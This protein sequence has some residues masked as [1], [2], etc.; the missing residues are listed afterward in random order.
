MVPSSRGSAGVAA[1]VFAAVLTL[2]AVWLFAGSRSGSLEEA[3]DARRAARDPGLNPPEAR[4]LL[5]RV[6]DLSK[7]LGKQ[8]DRVPRDV[9]LRREAPRDKPEE[10]L[11][12]PGVDGLEGKVVGSTILLTWRATGD[13]A[14]SG[15]RVESI[16]PDGVVLGNESLPSSAR[17]YRAV[18][19]TALR[20]RRT[21][22][23]SALS[24]DGTVADLQQKTISF[25]LEFSVSYVGEQA[26]GKARFRVT[27]DRDGQRLAEEFA[28]TV[29]DEIGKAVPGREDRPELDFGTG[30]RFAGFAGRR[31]METREASVPRFSPT[32]TLMRDEV[33]GEAVFDG[34]MMP[35]AV[36]VSGAEVEVPRDDGTVGRQ[37]VRKAKDG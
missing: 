1:L 36:V 37:W 32:G 14:A 13:E 10:K 22:R 19:L 11:S 12:P 27:W 26:D 33:T 17:R 31:L 9:K 25:R 28:V 24:R 7:R 29:G 30:W 23:V 4:A 16:G 6:D 18:P 5:G 20:G 8:V 35:V 15:Y 21:Y 3:I 34:R 2:F